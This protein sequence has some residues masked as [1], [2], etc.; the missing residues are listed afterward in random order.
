MISFRK[1]NLTNKT[2]EDLLVE[3]KKNTSHFNHLYGQALKENRLD[4]RALRHRK[5]LTQYYSHLSLVNHLVKF[6]K[7]IDKEHCLDCK[8]SSE[9]VLELRRTLP[10]IRPVLLRLRQAQEILPHLYLH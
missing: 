9:H 6:G 1:E 10:K 7:V 2:F 3:I 5:I 4:A 8:Y